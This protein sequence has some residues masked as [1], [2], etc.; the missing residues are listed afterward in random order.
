MNHTIRVSEQVVI[1]R[2]AQDARWGEQNHPDHH[3]NV[4]NA[5]P[6]RMYEIPSED[7]AKYTCEL[8]RDAGTLSWADI[9]LEEFVEALEAPTTESLREELIQVAAVAQAWVECI[10]RRAR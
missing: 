4:R 2:R 7:R 10:D 1:E 8:R 5:G 3:P 6:S 9:L